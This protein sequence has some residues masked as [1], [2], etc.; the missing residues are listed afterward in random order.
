M[1][2]RLMLIS[3]AATPAMR[4]GR[5]P[6]DDA[7]DAR[8]AA[9]AG[10]WPHRMSIG[11]DAPVFCSPA[12]AALDTARALGFAVRIAS[13]LADAD[14]GE[15]RG[16]RLADVAGDARSEVEAWSRD[17]HAAP[18]RGESFEQVRARVGGWLEQL[19]DAGDIVALTHAA[20]MRAAVV[21]A[22]N[23]PSSSFA[24]IEI[25][26]LSVLELRRSARGWTW[27]PARL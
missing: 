1:R 21:H 11:A 2:T 22:L 4:E 19:D 16:R 9:D 5:F 8:G 23:A 20:V 12:A 18:P 3:H 15:W 14:Y 10:A 7:L 26:P 25:A 17:P 27:W 6:A 13:E 24:R